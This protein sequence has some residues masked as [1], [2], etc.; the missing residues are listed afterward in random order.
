[1][2]GTLSR[3]KG[4]I[5]ENKQRNLGILG[6]F[7]VVVLVSLALGGV[8]GLLL[9]DFIVKMLK[10]PAWMDRIL[11]T[12][13]GMLIS[14]LLLVICVRKIILNPL[15]ELRLAIA[16]MA[17]GDLGVKLDVKSTDEIGILMEE[18]NQMAGNTEKLLK[19]IQDPLE[20][21]EKMSEGLSSISEQTNIASHEIAKT[22]E[23]V[24]RSATDQASNAEVCAS[25]I[26][27]L[28]HTMEMITK[29][30][31]TM[32]EFAQKAKEY[33]KA[34]HEIVN[35]LTNKSKENSQVTLE[36][37]Q[38]VQHVDNSIKH[39]GTITEV[40]KQ[41]ANQINLLALNAAIESARA[42]EAGKGFAVV[43]EEVRKLAEQS[44]KAVDEI[45]DVISSIQQESSIAVNAM[46]QVI[47]T[48]Q[49][50]DGAVHETETVFD[51]ITDSINALIEKVVEVKEHSEEMVNMK[52]IVMDAV[53]S[54]T[55]TSQETAAATEQISAS[56]EENLAA[57]EEIT[58]HSGKL[59][60]IT[61]AIKVSISS[62]KE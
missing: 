21:L 31:S 38:T 58:T 17:K 40:I 35:L 29:K 46:E 42:G 33:S 36:V 13:L 54:V 15:K 26:G 43:A 59:N 48:V 8:I 28:A 41:I 51:D 56:N 11:L 22:M 32:N 3:D 49:E 6:K 55:T 16:Q 61:N 18:F 39:I 62:F 53:E 25:A 19:G 2:K 7:I 30:T 23:D 14:T 20:V 10:M 5:G 34:G 50:Q 44:S 12:F 37:N 1:M 27:E 47:H 60:E 4:F 57:I 45:E 9:Q 52:D 24:A